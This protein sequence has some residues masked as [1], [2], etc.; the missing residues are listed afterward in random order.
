MTSSQHGGWFRGQA[1]DGKNQTEAELPHNLVMKVMQHY[2][3]H[4]E[5]IESR[6]LGHFDWG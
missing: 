1:S 2:F 4:V 3:L 5:F 6:S